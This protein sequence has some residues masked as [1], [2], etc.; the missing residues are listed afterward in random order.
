MKFLLT[1][2]NLTV[3]QN[4]VILN[5]FIDHSI[6]RNWDGFQTKNHF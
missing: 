5:A 2:I 1:Y 3:S 4:T 6:T